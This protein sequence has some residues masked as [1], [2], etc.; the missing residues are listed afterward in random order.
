LLTIL[1]PGG[2]LDEKS[3]GWK[4]S[5]T[6]NNT[7]LSKIFLN[8]FIA[9]V[10]LDIDSELIRKDEIHA[11][12]LFGRRGIYGMTDQVDSSTGE[13]LGSRLYP[14][15]VTGILWMLED[16]DFSRLV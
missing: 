2:C 5:S 16:R 3:G 10:I 12:W 7:W 4:L 8:Q 11:S 15:L 13:D 9:D 1:V 6:S 14:R